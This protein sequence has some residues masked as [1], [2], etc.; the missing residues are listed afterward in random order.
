MNSLSVLLIEDNPGDAFLIEEMLNASKDWKFQ[1]IKAITLKQALEKI[2]NH[3]IEVIIA[4]LGLPDSQGIATVYEILKNVKSI[5]IIVLTGMNDEQTGNEAVIR[6]AQD[7]LI[8]WNINPDQLMRSISYSFHRKKIEEKLIASEEK[9]RQV[10]ENIQL[11]GLMLNMDGKIIFANDYL[12]KLS[13]WKREEVIGKDWLEVFVPNHIK[14][15]ISRIYKEMK[16][17]PE[18]P[19]AYE[20]EVLTRDGKLLVISWSNMVHY[21]QNE[22]PIS[23]TSIGENISERI[24]YQKALVKNE[25]R[26]RSIIE[27]QT[28]AIARYKPSGILNFVNDSFCSQQN[29]KREEIIGRSIFSIIDPS[30]LNRVKKKIESLNKVN[31]VLTD[32]HKIIVSGNK[33][34]WYSWTDRAIFDEH[35]NIAEYQSEGIDITERKMAEEALQESEKKFRVMVEASPDAVIT[36]DM[37]G[38]INYA[39]KRASDLFGFKKAEL[40]VGT[41]FKD[42]VAPEHHERIKSKMG[43]LLTEGTLL[44]VLY[45]MNRK[46]GA[47]FFG[48]VSSSLI[49]NKEGEPEGKISIIKDITERKNAESAIKAYQQNLRSMASELNLAEE[50]ERRKIAVDLHDDLG[51]TLAMTRIKLS[52]IKSKNQNAEIEEHLLEMEKHVTH[53]IKNSRSLTYELSPPILYEFGLAAAVNWKLEQLLGEHNINTN[54]EV[55]DELPELREDLLILL[56]RAVGELLNNIVKHAQ[57]K[58][59]SVTFNMDGKCLNILVTDDGKGFDALKPK[60]KDGHTSG[61]GLFSLRERLEYFDGTLTIDSNINKGTK[62]YITLPVIFK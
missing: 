30:D 16:N 32:E 20:Y 40:L 31:P 39:S 59:V 51:Q 14:E 10:I 8:K 22:N 58:N 37:A 62:V 15:K 52:A 28:Q 57:A 54:M 13:G 50:K 38:K 21:D 1:V 36:L 2:Q 43:K 26:Y 7:Y 33:I 44:D 41:E 56:F 19:A 49:T 9:F 42:L 46:G 29:K 5:P 47:R 4:D 45:I 24:N 12:L 6:G 34:K 60:K 48:E 55:T 23:I 35:G 3:T 25:K 18:F 11:L 27:D 17:S 53:A 61:I